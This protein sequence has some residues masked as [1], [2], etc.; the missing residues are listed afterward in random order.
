MRESLSA[1]CPCYPGYSQTIRLWYCAM[2]P[3][4][5]TSCHGALGVPSSKQAR[6]Q[7]SSEG[8]GWRFKALLRMEPDGGVTNIRNVTSKHWTRWP[9]GNSKLLHTPRGSAPLFCSSGRR[10]CARH[11]SRHYPAR[12]HP[13]DAGYVVAPP[14]QRSEGKSYSCTPSA[15]RLLAKL[16]AGR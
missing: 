2:A 3:T 7:A 9:A 16:A 11:Q 15:A 14:S 10:A 6:R 8:Q 1:I 4:E 12:G 5:Y 13:G